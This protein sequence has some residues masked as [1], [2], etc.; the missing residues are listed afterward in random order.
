MK[1]DN[2]NYDIFVEDMKRAGLEID[3]DYRGRFFYQGPAVVVD[4]IQVAMSATKVK[5][6]WDNLGKSYIVY[7]R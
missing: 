6:Q 1:Y 4:D 5:C 2:K 3:E 7:P